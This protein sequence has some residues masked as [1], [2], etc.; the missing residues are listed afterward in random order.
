MK[1]LLFSMITLILI[2]AAWACRI[3]LEESNLRAQEN[4]WVKSPSFTGVSCKRP[5]K[6]IG[7]TDLKLDIRN[8]RISYRVFGNF[9]AG[10]YRGFVSEQ[11]EDGSGIAW[12]ITNDG[13]HVD[14]VRVGVKNSK[15]VVMQIMGG[16]ECELQ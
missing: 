8:L 11:K 1:K 16:A 13:Y 12:Y 5:N 9:K 14:E 6:Q 2:L 3:R 10:T 4:E 7:I 15:I